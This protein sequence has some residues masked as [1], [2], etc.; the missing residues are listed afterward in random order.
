M[1][2]IGRQLQ[3]LRNLTS[4]MFGTGCTTGD[5]FDRL[6]AANGLTRQSFSGVHVSPKLAMQ[7]CAVYACVRVISETMASIPLVVYRREGGAKQRATDHPLYPLLHHR[8]NPEQTSFELRETLVAHM[9]LR[10][11][12]YAYIERSPSGR[13][14]GL[15]P[16]H[17]DHV[18]PRE[19]E[20]QIVYDV[21]A[22]SRGLLRYPARDILH[23][24]GLSDDG[25][26]GI[27][28]VDALCNQI[29]S[30]YA[31]DKYSGDFFA[32]D[33]TPGGAIVIDG[34][35]ADT[36]EDE[37]AVKK[38]IR[39]DWMAIA[40]E[41]RHAPVVFS[42]G[43]KWESIG[44][45][46]RD[47]QMLETRN[48][49]VTE[50]A[51]GARVPPS[52]I[53]HNIGTDL[54]GR[55]EEEALSF[56]VDCV[57]PMAVRIEQRLAHSLLDGDDSIFIEFNLDGLLRGDIKTRYDAYAVG[58]E[59]GWFNADEI[60]QLENMNPIEGG[61][62]Q[63]YWAQVNHAP[64]QKILAGDATVDG[65]GSVV[66]DRERLAALMAGKVNGKHAS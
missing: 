22:K 54:K 65:D 26:V 51:R 47:A 56:V 42:R 59:R 24:K 4:R 49:S 19:I 64:I 3:K 18:T 46:P 17:P 45:S 61:L 38:A 28:L 8:P 39:D 63:I 27:G 14:I 2:T 7:V 1:G 15:W 33:A 41:D 58:W 30:A 13:I 5:S 60:R 53:F 11:N 16:I 31:A 50:I 37:R 12:G 40:R 44:I 21:F 62:G 57:R 6:F 66:A 52:K 55:Y 23:L 36:P 20:D 43:M 35:L 9:V 48:F 25:L 34:P 29:G 10:G 32:N